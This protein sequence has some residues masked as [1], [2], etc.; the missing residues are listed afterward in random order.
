MPLL[1]ITTTADYY[2]AGATTLE[3]LYNTTACAQ[4]VVNRYIQSKRVVRTMVED[5][6]VP[7]MHVYRM[8]ASINHVSA[9]TMHS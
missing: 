6:F 1:I 7:L 8:P 3:I 9:E 5:A 4:S 2:C